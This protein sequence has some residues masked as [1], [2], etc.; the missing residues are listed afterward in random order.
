VRA[1]GQALGSFTHWFMCAL[2]A[3]YFP[4][5][6]KSS[7]GYPFAVFAL[8]MVVQFFVVL[9]PETKGVSLEDLERKL[10]LGHEAGGPRQRA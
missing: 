7:G 6:A 1:K 3:T 8:V 10:G 4:T 2:L 5:M 9:Y